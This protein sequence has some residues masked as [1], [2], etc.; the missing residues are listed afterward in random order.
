M[1]K[2]YTIGYEGADVAQF[3]SAL[4]RSG[5]K[6]LADVRAAEALLPVFETG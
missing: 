2:L 1:I 3:T 5:V 6:V 4:V